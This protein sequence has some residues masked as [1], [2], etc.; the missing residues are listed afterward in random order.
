MKYRSLRSV[1]NGLVAA[2]RRSLFFV[3][4]WQSMYESALKA[5]NSKTQSELIAWTEFKSRY[6]LVDNR[7]IER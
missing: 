4:I 6:K 2:M 5:G 7:W 1:P 3:N